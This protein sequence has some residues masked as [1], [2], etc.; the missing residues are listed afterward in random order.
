MKQPSFVRD[1]E[2]PLQNRMDPEGCIHITP[3]RGTMMGNRGGRIHDPETKKLTNRRWANKAWIICV[4]EFNN[5]QRTLMG[6]SYTELF[7][8]DEVT[9][10]AAGHRPC[11]ECRRKAA[12]AY[13]AAWQSAESLA[14]APKVG[15][16]DPILHTE[17]LDGKVQRHH[18][19]H[20]S[21][22]VD[23][24][25][26]LHEGERYAAK[27]GKLLRWSFEGYAKSQL[28]LG[29]L[30]E[31]CTS[32]TPPASVNALRH[33]YQPIWHPSAI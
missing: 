29:D 33:G 2:M 25:V 19:I 31:I 22:V 27:D 16:M 21:D 1:N 14:E 5:R 18:S 20:K 12:K 8:L 26:L 17:R 28:S 10:L 15:V 23:G 30:P 6:Y 4:T 7:F 11:F 9:A 13:Q 24:V 3:S 32:L